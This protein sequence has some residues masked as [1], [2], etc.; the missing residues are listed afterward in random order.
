MP[1]CWNRRGDKPPAA[2]QP[3][4]VR[5][6]I[7]RDLPRPLGVVRIALEVAPVLS[8]QPAVGRPV[9]VIHGAVQRRQPTGDERLTQAARRSRQVVHH[10]EAAEALPQD[11]PLA[12]RPQQLAADEL[13]VAH[14]VVGTEMH[15][16]VGLRL[17][18]AAP[19]QRLMRH[20]RAAAR[21]AVVQQQDA[22]V[23]QR[24]LEP[25]G[26]AI[27]PRRPEAGAALEEDQPGQICVLLARR[28]DLA[29]EDGDLFAVG[30]AVVER[31][32]EAMIG[33]DQAGNAMGEGTHKMAP[34]CKKW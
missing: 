14:D 4:V 25:A 21:A 31:D 13:G 34:V 27:R 16:V 26:A 19:R 15:Q 6:Q 32:S 18:R 30:P 23:L 8:Q 11:A 33:Q 28:D 22:I 9:D 5:G 12:L 2:R 29:G 1:S 24:A 17:G 7:V 10:A 3:H 20:R